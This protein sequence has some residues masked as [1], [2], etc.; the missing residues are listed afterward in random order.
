MDKVLE[1]WNRSKR[2][3]DMSWQERQLLSNCHSEN[4]I[5]S[6][7]WTL[8]CFFTFFTFFF[9]TKL[10][11]VCV[12]GN[13][14]FC[15]SERVKKVRHAHKPYKYWQHESWIMS[16]HFRLNAAAV[17][18]SQSTTLSCSSSSSCSVAAMQ[19]HSVTIKHT[20]THTAA[21]Y[22]HTAF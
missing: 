6:A 18:P 10:L 11:N 5:S 4:F 19:H 16:C 20:Q 8:S 14:T 22:T 13:K 2:G 3:Q 9:F 1:S 17:C 7:A 12:Y 15:C 21:R